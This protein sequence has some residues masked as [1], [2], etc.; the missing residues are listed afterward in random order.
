[1]LLKEFDPG[2]WLMD[3]RPGSSGTG[4]VISS[5]RSGDVADVFIE[6]IPSKITGYKTGLKVKRCMKRALLTL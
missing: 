1:V 2:D 6:D 4:R 5:K 3:G